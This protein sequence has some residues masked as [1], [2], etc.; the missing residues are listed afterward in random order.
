[1]R[2]RLSFI[3][4]AVALLAMG[5][6]SIQ[7]QD[8]TLDESLR[9]E[10]VFT[11]Q[12]GEAQTKTAFQADETSIW[13][14]PGDQICVYSGS[15]GGSLFTSTNETEVAST[16]FSGPY[17]SYPGDGQYYWAIYP[18]SAAY[19]CDGSSVIVTLPDQ[20]TAKAGSFAPNTNITVARS[21]DS[22]LFFYNTCSWFRFTVTKEGVKS[23]TFRGNNKEYVAGRFTV[24]MD[25]NGIPT[26]PKLVSGVN[27]ITLTPPYG[28]T[29]QVGEMYYITLLPQVFTKG[30]TVIFDTETET[31]SRCISSEATF[32][33]ARYNTGRQFDQNITY[34]GALSLSEIKSLPDNNTVRT[35]PLLVVSK[36]M[37]GLL[38]T[39]GDEMIYA[40]GRYLSPV[41]G[42]LVQLK[43]NLLTYYQNPD[44]QEFDNILSCRIVSSGNP[45]AHPEPVD[46]TDVTGI[47]ISSAPFNNYSYIKFR[48][49]YHDKAIDV[50]KFVA[51]DMNFHNIDPGTNRIRIFYPYDYQDYS[52]YQPG[53]EIDVAGYF[54]GINDS[55]GIV[56]MPTSMNMVAFTPP[57]P[58]DLGIIMT[59]PDGSQYN[60]L[61]STCNLGARAPE[62][63][64]DYF[65]WGETE[66]KSDYS[67]STYHWCSGT[68]TSLTKYNCSSFNGPVV[69]D[70]YE[71][72]PE[73][74]AA[75]INWGG[76][77]RMPKISEWDA[78]I[79]NCTSC[80]T[81]R[82]GV[83]GVI[84]TSK[85]NGNSIFLPAA[86]WRAGYAVYGQPYCALY[87]SSSLNSLDGVGIGSDSHVGN[88]LH[89]S[90]DSRTFGRS[91]RPVYEIE[92]Q[93]VSISKKDMSLY[94]GDSA[95]LSAIVTPWTATNKT[96]NWSS[97]D[98]SVATVD[99]EGQVTGVKK[100]TAVITVTA[101][102]GGYKA[103]CS[104][105]VYDAG[106]HIPVDLGLGI[107]WSSINLGALSP[108][109]YGNYYAWGET[110]TKT[111]YDWSTY[112][113]CDGT[114]TSFTK[115][116]SF[117]STYG[118]RDNK[119][120]LDPEDDAANVSLGGGWRMPTR[121]E[122]D[123]LRKN[124][125]WVWHAQNGVNG[126]KVISK[127]NANSLFIPA[128]GIYVSSTIS[129]QGFSGNYW[130]SSQ[131][132]YEPVS[133]Y[134]GCFYSGSSGY[135]Y[136]M[137][138]RSSGLSI[139]P[140]LDD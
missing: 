124:C 63:Y 115:Y 61:W 85:I 57:D 104:V 64:G 56:C 95:T 78:L 22:N 134:V 96:V 52:P 102:E 140:V 84:L 119:S 108:E 126:M 1:M 2:I 45:V 12:S 62:Q 127:T 135:S 34:R 35:N 16:D 40:Y 5:A 26:A 55:N 46:V 53:D 17:I 18:Y 86:G 138:Y 103:S 50:R 125:Y 36:S 121:D 25:E 89:H 66:P 80:W 23:V 3:C 94:V 72:D 107:K 30:F 21:Q 128:A 111:D 123:Y 59:R 51:Y 73:D 109:E 117:S 132:L 82:N 71:L 77:W 68:E 60:L 70:K 38:L 31:A 15:F 74:D 37:Y 105:K 54:I 33:R 116:N 7:E 47:D 49:T 120:Q 69:D 27:T 83:D 14:S 48:A 118:T 76:Y 112:L 139:R 4:T 6:C 97:D 39:E 11:A 137:S 10:M 43:A 24:S 81:K 130:T 122:W 8:Y 133:S 29:F 32:L 110:E 114:N 41:V 88:Q 9:K 113:W 20:Q 99:S 100:G 101:M 19:A 92:P 91:I 65:A 44:L 67:W 129:A 131:V 87:W 42:D 136:N 79:E 75:R 58:V 93:G 106:T 90:V 13:W 98:T 28:E